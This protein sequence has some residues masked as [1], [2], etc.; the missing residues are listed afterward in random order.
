[1]ELGYGGRILLAGDMARRSYLRSWGGGPGYPFILGS[2]LPGLVSAGLSE[3][4]ARAL[5]VENPARFLV[6]ATPHA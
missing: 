4:A 1:V 2:F 3:D 5:V 6:W